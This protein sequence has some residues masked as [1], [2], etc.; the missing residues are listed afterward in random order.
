MIVWGV[1]QIVRGVAQRSL[2]IIALESNRGFEETL[3]AVLRPVPP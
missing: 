2:E 3:V 1:A